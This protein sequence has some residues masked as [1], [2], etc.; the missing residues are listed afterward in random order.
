MP[1][2]QENRKFL[3]RVGAALAVTLIGFAI[4]MWMYSS[5]AAENGE[6]ADRVSQIE[7]L[8][9]NLGDGEAL[10][11]GKE[12]VLS[13]NWN[14]VRGQVTQTLQPKFLFA[15]DKKD[16]RLISEVVN[17]AGTWKET[18]EKKDMTVD[19]TLRN[20]GGL[21]TDAS[22][23]EVDER[24]ARLDL[25]DRVMAGIDE[26]GL[27]A[28]GGIRHEK[29]IQIAI[30]DS[31]MVILRLPVRIEVAGPFDEMA[32][33]LRRIEEAGRY[34]QVIEA[35]LKPDAEHS[36]RGVLVVAALEIRKREDSKTGTRGGT[37]PS[38]RTPRRRR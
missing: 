25:L 9:R 27:V 1:F 4:V 38:R 30:P 28:V 23:Q 31:D 19:D 15:D 5:A 2:W 8:S 24:I 20:L 36:V 6:N 22:I 3:I 34:T 11:L 21:G 17:V 7:I 10:E 29:R 13:G 18:F 37:R 12:R 33:F 16:V 14:E 26:T 32:A 35:T